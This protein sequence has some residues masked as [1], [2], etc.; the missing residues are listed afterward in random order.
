M[1]LN[2]IFW[3]VGIALLVLLCNCFYLAGRLDAIAWSRAGREWVKARDVNAPFP[4]LK[5]NWKRQGVNYLLLIML[6]IL[7]FP[8]VVK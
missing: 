7:L 2:M 8:G 3:I 1:S 6:A 4:K 5:V